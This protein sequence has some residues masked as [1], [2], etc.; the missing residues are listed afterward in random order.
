M[1]EQEDIALEDAHVVDP[2]RVIGRPSLS[3]LELRRFELLKAPG[4]GAHRDRSLGRGADLEH[5]LAR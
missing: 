2:D 4:G 3:S 5:R 1:L